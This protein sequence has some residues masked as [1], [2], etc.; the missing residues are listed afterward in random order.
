MPATQVLSFNVERQA[1]EAASHRDGAGALIAWQGACVLAGGSDGMEFLQ[2]GAED[3][4]QIDTGDTDDGEPIAYSWTSKKFPL[5]AVSMIHSVFFRATATD[6]TM[7]L[8]VR[9]GGSEYGDQS[10]SYDLDLSG[11]GEVET[12]VRVH[13]EALGRW[14]QVEV[15]GSVEEAPAIREVVLRVIPVRATRVSA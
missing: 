8:V 13:R 7:S 5:D 11:S 9:V 2:A 14:V 6:D 15:S 12:R 3:V 4:Y 10:F 1:W